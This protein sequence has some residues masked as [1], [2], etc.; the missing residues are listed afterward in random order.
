VIGAATLETAFAWQGGGKR[1][2]PHETVSADL[3]GK[4]I[5]ITYGRPYLK[6]RKVGDQVAPFGKVWRLGADEATKITVAAPVS[7]SGGPTLSPG[8]Y[9]LFAIPGTDKWTVIVNKTADQWGAFDYDQ[10]KDL[11][12]FDVPVQ[13]L[14][15]PVEQFTI[16]LSKQSDSA[17]KL[18]MSWGDESVA[19]TLKTSG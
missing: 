9:A 1:V 17:A 14:S 6:G 11:G 18:V 4:A 3:G 16:G 2:S 5:T 19:T 7:F 13:K 12:R 15:A 8:S 10:S